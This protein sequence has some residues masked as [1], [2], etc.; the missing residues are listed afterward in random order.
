LVSSLAA[1]RPQ[2]S[3]YALTK[4]EGE[5]VLHA[6]RDLPWTIIRPPALYGPGD[7]EMLPLL[8]WLRRGFAPVTG[9]N[10]HRLP[11]LPDD[12]FAD[13]EIGKT[14]VRERGWPYR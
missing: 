12:G 13:A 5:A 7:Q 9:P 1:S 8:R 10:D 6:R 11:L 4:H 3:D 14:A 2:V